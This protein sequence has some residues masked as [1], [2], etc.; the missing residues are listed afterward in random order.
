MEVRDRFNAM[1]QINK[2]S[3]VKSSSSDG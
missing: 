2:E 3:F 1:R